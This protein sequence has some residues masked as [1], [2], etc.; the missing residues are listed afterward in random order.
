MHNLRSCLHL[1]FFMVGAQKIFVSLHYQLKIRA[2]SPSFI[3]AP[4][5]PRDGDT[6]IVRKSC[7]SPLRRI[8][9]INFKNGSI[10]NG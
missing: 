3:I 7:N 10:S 1:C 2:L 4:L 5:E 9:S 8:G 6:T